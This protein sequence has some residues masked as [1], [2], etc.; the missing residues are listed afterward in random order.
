[1]APYP[2][3]VAVSVQ[4]VCCGS[5][6]LLYGH[7]FFLQNYEYADSRTRIVWLQKI[8]NNNIIAKQT[9]KKVKL[10]VVVVHKQTKKQLLWMKIH[11]FLLR[12]FSVVDAPCNLTLLCYCCCHLFVIVINTTCCWHV[13]NVN[14]ASSLWEVSKTM[15][16]GAGGGSG[17][18]VA[19]WS[20]SPSWRCCWLLTLSLTW[21]SL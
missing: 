5:F 15:P 21:T 20:C 16:R 11:F 2:C 7:K 13:L 19:C 6:H 14:C 3:S 18:G 8:S 12:R 10:Y 4:F 9:M 1:M 17:V